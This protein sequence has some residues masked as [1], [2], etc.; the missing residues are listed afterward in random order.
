[1][2][3]SNGKEET[4]KYYFTK[5]K[6]KNPTETTQ[7]MTDRD[8]AQINA[9]RIVW[10]LAMILLCW[11]HVLHA[12]QQHFAITHYPEAWSALKEL[13]RAPTA[14]VFASV[15]KKFKSNAPASLIEYLDAEWMTGKLGYTG[16]VF[17]VLSLIFPLYR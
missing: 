15:Y 7:I 5:F 17:I 13:V 16:E 12:W 8:Q 11:W 9:A 2:L 3:A 1:M 6:E 14:S 4:L 10:P